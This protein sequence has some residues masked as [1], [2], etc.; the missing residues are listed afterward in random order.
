MMN[1]Q[2]WRKGLLYMLLCAII[3][4]G[5]LSAILVWQHPTA[6]PAYAATK[7]ANTYHPFPV[8]QHK[9]S[10]TSASYYAHLHP[11]LIAPLRPGTKPP[12]HTTRPETHKAKPKRAASQIAHPQG[13]SPNYTDI[14]SFNFIVQTPVDASDGVPVTVCVT[15]DDDG[16][17]VGEDVYLTADS[18]STFTTNLVTLDNNGCG[19]SLLFVPTTGTIT[20]F[21]AINYITPAFNAFGGYDEYGEYPLPST[22]STQIDAT[23]ASIP[24]P[25]DI[26]F[27]IGHGSSPLAAEPVN[28]ALGNFTYQ[29]TDSSIPVRIQSLVMMRSYNSLSTSTGPIGIGW[30][31][32]YNQSI[33]FPTSTTAAVIY[34]DGHADN[35]TL[36]N[37]VYSPSPGVGVLSTLTLNGDGTYTVTYKD[38]SQDIYSATGRLLSMVDRNGNKL[39]L[40]YNG[41]GQLTL[42]ADASGRG[43]SFSYDGNGH[44]TTVTDPLGLKTQYAYDG[45]N[46]LISVKDPLN[47]QTSYTYDSSSRLLTITDPLGHVV[48]NNTYD[49]SGRVIK[50]VNAA[51]ATTTF[52]YSP[53]S[54]TVTDPLGHTTTYAFDFLYR[55][56]SKTDA[57]GIVTD[58]TYDNNAE[59]TAVTDGNG[60]TTLYTYD[61]QGNLLS[62]VD[63]VGVSLANPNGYTTSYTYDSQNHLLTSTDANGNTTTYTYDASGN[64]LTISD[65]LG[66]V[67]SYSYD[68][69]G[70]RTS[71]TSPD[72]GQHVTTYTYDTYGDRIS[73]RDGMGKTTNTTYDA[74]GRPTK[75]TDA[76]GH[77]ISTVYDADNRILSATD[78][79]GKQTTYT[80]DANGNRLSITNADGFVT[81]YAYDA[82]NRL[83]AVNNP[84]GTSTKY[85]YDANSNMLQQVNGAGHTTTY[86]YD[87]DNR[88]LTTTDAVGHS[89]T[90]SYDGAGN[91]VTKVDGNNMATA[92]GYDANN[93]MVQISYADGLL[94]SFNYD[95]VGNRLSMTDSTG[96]TYYAFDQLNRQTS[97]TDAAGRTL[98]FSY[99][100]AG[101][102]T[103]MTYPDGRT[104]SYTY[105]N[106]SRL[107]SVIDWANR[108]TKYSYDAVG[109]LLKLSLPN[110][111]VTS[112][113]YDADN[114]VIRVSNAES[115]GVISAFRYTLDAIG[116]RT[117]VIVTGKNAETGTLKYSY[118]SM[119]RLL[120][121]TNP[122]GSIAQ[123]TYDAAGNRV[124]L[125]QIAGKTTKTTTYTYDAADELLST[126]TGTNR[127]TFSYKGNGNLNIRKQGTTTTKYV[128]DVANNLVSVTAGTTKITYSYN[129]DGFRV[130]KS[131]TSGTT[132]SSTQYVLSPTKLP[133]VMEEITSQNTTDNLYGKSLLASDPSSTPDTPS[134]YSYDA[135]GN[136]RNLTDSSGSVLVQESYYAFGALRKISGTPTEFQ[137]DA[138]QT[139]N[140]DGLIYMRGRYYDSSVGRFIMRDITPD[141]LAIPQALNRYVYSNNDPIGLS[142]PSGNAFGLDDLFATVGGAIVGG[143]ITLASE[144][145]QG[146]A[147]NWREVGKSALD[148][149]VTAE[150]FVNPAIGIPATILK[151]GL[152]YCIDACGQPDF[153]W[154]QLALH[155]AV[156]T[157]ID[158]VTGQV[159][160]EL[161][162]GTKITNI[163]GDALGAGAANAEGTATGDFLYRLSGWVTGGSIPSWFEGSTDDWNRELGDTILEYLAGKFED[164]LHLEDRIVKCLSQ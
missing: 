163:I 127:I 132:M 4:S 78:A 66:G 36:S 22:A 147:I 134:Y 153:S 27:G 57:L 110:G 56:T 111:V 80:Y 69:F 150:T 19:S 3:M 102:E 7:T 21:A 156:G 99:D 70:E 148:G 16:S 109:N 119:G 154:G 125:V 65:P 26:S 106:D 71:S 133:Q 33:T 53:G 81:S 85:S 120:S 17:A 79:L 55:Q 113:T 95:G 126:L 129:G 122:D 5:E 44:I 10:Y 130:G 108:I 91:I 146:E 40:T 160:K 77:A 59:L 105:D 54:T 86:T 28:V 31:F 123:Y 15:S 128:Y 12:Y 58:Y 73:S 97:V 121:A 100:A 38:Q 164:S 32:I 2:I 139:D 50:Q 62:I 112:Y 159:I 151:N 74:D 24:L 158:L 137:F 43:L 92:Y 30:N 101:N 93:Q 37:G 82:M 145:L 47:N 42:V 88:L 13:S 138:Q 1:T 118:D 64:V 72:G 98:T 25:D 140:E 23:T 141:T 144:A 51:G 18:N 46:H 114:R 90:Y 142:D 143:G 135:S 75:V 8:L 157:A 35:Y 89:M 162:I 9:V 94:T 152:D 49:S 117:Q 155:T 11:P 60:D 149:A 104:V 34:G 87:A 103:G 76:N 29:H 45:N 48:V 39:T 41:A 68:S 83:I 6:L 115:S 136:V 67:T 14:F 124:K 161:G 107:S 116:N 61:T 20:I 131:V 63:A 52:A 84:D 96:T